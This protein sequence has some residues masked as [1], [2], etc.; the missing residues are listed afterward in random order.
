[1]RRNR[2]VIRIVALMLGLLRGDRLSVP[3]LAEKHQV[4][5]ETIYRDLR[6]LEDLGFPI[7]GDL[8][9]YK[10]RPRL[11]AGYQAKLMP[12]PFTLP[13]LTALCFSATLTEH[14]TGT[15]LHG[16]L[17][18]AIAKIRS[19]VPTASLPLL[20]AASTVFGSFKRGY[21]DYRPHVQTITR[22][23]QAMLERKRCQVTYHSFSQ[24]KP[25]SFVMDPYK[26]FE[27]G[28]SLYL[29]AYVQ[30]DDQVLTL[31]VE[32]ITAIT[33][34]DET[35]TVPPTFDF[36]QL[37]DQTFGV[38]M[39]APITVKIQFR[40]DQVPY[41]KERIWHPTQTFEDLPTGDTI[42]TFRAGG[43]FEIMRWV[44]GW[45]SAARVL[46]P[47]S[48]REAIRLEHRMALEFDSAAS[49]VARLFVRVGLEAGLPTG[50]FP[51]DA[52]PDL[53]EL[54][55]PTSEDDWNIFIQIAAMPW[56]RRSSESH[57]LSRTDPCALRCYRA[58]R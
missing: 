12:I 16:P 7:T 55:L 53:E 17:Q 43:E 28:G 57:G 13:E 38:G 44:L 22:L 34:T 5:R 2:Q 50:I 26:L 19:H 3:A 54:R 20:D 45:G 49:E 10:S 31:A 41:V 14:L 6:A 42:M 48:V 18:D 24:S 39:E 33:P 37:R 52:R 47:A 56:T 58:L 46:E 27:F 1:M 25:P 30:K 15:A 40:K 11:R 23:V 29:F 9:G 36:E 4:R 32:R 21:K 51:A 35:F 8:H